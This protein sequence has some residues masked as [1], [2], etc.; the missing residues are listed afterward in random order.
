MKI[1]PL[2]AKTYILA[3][4][5]MSLVI[6]IL[7][8]GGESQLSLVKLFPFVIFGALSEMFRLSALTVNNQGFNMS[9]GAAVILAGIIL[10]SPQEVVIFATAYGV[11]LAIF[12]KI[13]NL[14]KAVF[15]FSETLNVTYLTYLVWHAL[16]IKNESLLVAG[17]ILPLIITMFVFVIV[18]LLAVST[19]VALA[20]ETKLITIW[21]ESFDWV[22]VSYALIAF[23]GLI[24]AVAY[25]LFSVY[26]LI[27]FALPLLLMQYNMHLFSKQKE[28]QVKQLQDFSE[29]LKAN[30][31]QLIFMLSQVIDARDNSLYGHSAMVAKYS[32]A[33][34]LLLGLS[35]EQ[36]DQLKRSA[37]LHDIGKLGVSENL[38][39][40]PG[41]LTYDEFE[42]VKKHTTIGERLVEKVKGM[43]K[44]ATIIGQHHEYFSGEGYPYRLSGEKI[45]LESRIISVCDALDTML[46]TRP[47]KQAWTLELATEELIRCGGK[48][49]DPSVVNAFLSLKDNSPTDFFRNSAGTQEWES[50]F[51]RSS[52]AGINDLSIQSLTNL[53]G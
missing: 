30:N 43:E 20:S 1:L 42:V 11:A 16:H 34:G 10:F 36:I 17:N 27:G 45:L 4:V 3:N 31:E 7:V 8:F 44:V 24:L 12:P 37:L 13:T 6:S 19:I 50:S 21:R 38:L 40:K 14:W 52:V 39:K 53:L 9:S 49:F 25:N 32:V 51:P 48:Q 23:M 46:S 15:N 22:L 33:I 26:G 35:E 18:D 29:V 28:A 41:K 47:Y 2:P 5:A